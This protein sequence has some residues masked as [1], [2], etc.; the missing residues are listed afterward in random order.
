MTTWIPTTWVNKVTNF[1]MV[2]FDSMLADTSRTL[3]K[4]YLAKASPR[5][6]KRNTIGCKIL[7]YSPT[8]KNGYVQLSVNNKKGPVCHKVA[9]LLANGPPPDT[10]SQASHL[11]GNA[12]CCAE[13][14]QVW[15]D[16]ETNNSRKGCKGFIKIDG[17][18]YETAECNHNPR[19]LTTVTA[20]SK[21][22]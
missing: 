20:A 4:D 11:C 8:K 10:D 1:K 16:P 13:V 21:V 15:E 5:R 22:E 6:I 7:Q 19:C 14:H 2:T 3:A 18:T 17:T 9:C 12:R